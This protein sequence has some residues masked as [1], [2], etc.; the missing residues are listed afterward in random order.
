MDSETNWADVPPDQVGPVDDDNNV[1]DSGPGVNVAPASCGL[2]DV[3]GEI[4]ISALEDEFLDSPPPYVEAVRANEAPVADDNVVVPTVAVLND[5]KMADVAAMDSVNVS[6]AEATTPTLPAP[7]TTSVV[8]PSTTPQ[9]IFAHSR[10]TVM[11]N[12]ESG[13]SSL[14]TVPLLGE[15][16]DHVAVQ[17]TV[18]RW[19]YS[20]NPPDVRRMPFNGLEHHVRQRLTPADRTALRM[21]A[22]RKGFYHKI[23]TVCY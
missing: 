3:V 7:V 14:S 12:L 19:K 21:S 10:P 16:S 15:P 2:S 13:R 23:I 18:A 9:V 1:S 17:P 22:H 5:V 8:T 20:P 4:E 6:T 11:K